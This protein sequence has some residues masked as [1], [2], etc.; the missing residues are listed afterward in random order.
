MSMKAK[1]H[2]INSM[3]WI[4]QRTCLAVG[5]GQSRWYT[6]AVKERLQ[7]EQGETGGLKAYP[8]SEFWASR[9]LER[10]KCPS[11]KKDMHHFLH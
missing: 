8:Q 11:S 1:V 9:P 2:A 10:R 3:C 4:I 5:S 7:K 6:I